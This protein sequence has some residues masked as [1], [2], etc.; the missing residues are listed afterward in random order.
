MPFK[1]YSTHTEIWKDI[2][3]IPGYQASSFGNIK[4]LDRQITKSDG[5][6][7]RRKGELMKLTKRVNSHGRETYYCSFCITG[8]QITHGVSTIIAETFLVKP[9]N[10]TNH[11]LQVGHQ[12]GN[13]LNNCVW[14]L[15][16][17]TCSENM[18]HA[19]L[20]G[21]IKY[22]KGGNHFNSKKVCQ[23]AL[24]GELIKCW[25]SV[26]EASI[27]LNIGQHNIATCARGRRRHAGGFVWKYPDESNIEENINLSN[28]EWKF[29]PS[30]DDKLQI[31]NYGRVRSVDREIYREDGIQVT[32]KGKIL[33]QNILN[34]YCS[35]Y[36]SSMKKRFYVH[37]LVAEAF[38]GLK[39]SS[40]HIVDHKDDNKTNNH[41][42]N[43]QWITRKQNVH[44]AYKTN[45]ASKVRG[46]EHYNSKPI[47]QYSKNGDFIKTWACTSDVCRFF[48]KKNMNSIYDNLRGKRKFAYGFIWKYANNNESREPI[49]KVVP[50]Q[51]SI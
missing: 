23:Y 43:L 11:P 47:N 32:Y 39:P 15:K 9:I 26:V 8:K 45:V 4:S 24:D 29:I 50:Y 31:S 16:W 41:V 25:S 33:R 10:T 12:D 42:N 27:E 5:V 13:T 38:I 18:K 14:N 19:H 36:L 2:P 22:E 30:S 1:D 40:E 48:N 46:G 35:L 49:Q 44:K 20:T 7:M 17:E 21:L 28:E 51:E 6:V 34:G 37:V 3:N